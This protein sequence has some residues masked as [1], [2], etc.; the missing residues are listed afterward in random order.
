M[1][2][3]QTNKLLIEMIDELAAL[4]KATIFD[5]MADYGLKIE[6]VPKEAEHE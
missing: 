3:E 4:R 2:K 1:T 6:L 5:V